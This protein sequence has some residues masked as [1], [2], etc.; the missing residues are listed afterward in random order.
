MF[1][2][3][4][5][6]NPNNPDPYARQC[7]VE[8][9]WVDGTRRSL[10]TITAGASTI[11]IRNGYGVNWSGDQS[12]ALNIESDTAPTQGCLF[13]GV[14]VDA[15][16]QESPHT[17]FAVSVSQGHDTRI[18]NCRFPAT[19]VV[20]NSDGVIIEDNVISHPGVAWAGGSGIQVRRECKN[21]TIRRNHVSVLG[22]PPD[23]SA[24]FH[25]ACIH[26]LHTNE[27]SP[28][29]V[30]IE[31]NVLFPGAG[32]SGIWCTSL[33]G[34]TAIADNTIDG[35]GTGRG[36]VILLDS[37]G[38]PFTDVRING[39]TIMNVS[40]DQSGARIVHDG[41]Q[42]SFGSITITGNQFSQPRATDCAIR[43]RPSNV[44]GRDGFGE[45]QVGENGRTPSIAH[46][47]LGI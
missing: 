26:I 39:N 42:G 47:V 8:N 4:K 27:H 16:R 35:G 40:P 7:V 19:V 2:F 44:L 20:T 25:V 9:F 34:V 3:G 21:L 33:A 31:G 37:S 18:A 32:L 36:I 38:L 24:L 23:P 43:F 46:E 6:D 17:S 29:D 13:D 22:P 5:S 12:A 45:V 41:R 15:P 11:T 1:Y 30:T 28:R 14:Y 10:V